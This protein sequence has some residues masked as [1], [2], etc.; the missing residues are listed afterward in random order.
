MKNV[1]QNLLL[2]INA[3]INYDLVLTIYD[4]PAPEW[5]R[6]TEEQRRRR[7]Q[8]HCTVN[9]I[10]TGCR[11]KSLSATIRPWTGS[12]G[13]SGGWTRGCFLC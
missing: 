1:L 7:F 9:V 11:T 10:I 5:E 4:M 13:I 3:H 8:D 2:G 12:T 6:L